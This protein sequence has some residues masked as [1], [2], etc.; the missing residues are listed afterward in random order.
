M[1][2]SS[3]T[4]IDRTERLLTRDEN[5]RAILE[6]LFLIDKQHFERYFIKC[7]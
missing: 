3:E 2:K 5:Y 7:T 6:K 1:E 4:S